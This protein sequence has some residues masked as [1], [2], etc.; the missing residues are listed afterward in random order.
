MSTAKIDFAMLSLRDA[1]DLGILIEEEARERYEELA[2]QMDDRH[3]R[4]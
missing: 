3:R 2:A 1:L 4:Q